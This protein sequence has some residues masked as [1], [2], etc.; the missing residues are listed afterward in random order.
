MKKVGKI[1]LWIVLSLV[2]VVLLLLAINAFDEDLSPEATALV[3]EP[4]TPVPPNENAY[5]TVFGFQAPPGQDAHARGIEIV[6]E[7]EKI[8]KADPFVDPVRS[9]DEMLG[10]DRLQFKGDEK[11]LCSRSPDSSRCITYYMGNTGDVDRLLADN[12]LLLERYFKLTSYPHYRETLPVV[13][14][15]PLPHLSFVRMA[16]QLMLAKTAL[17][18]K[19]G[20]VAAALSQLQRDAVFNRRMAEEGSTLISKL[21][22]LSLLSSDARALSEIIAANKLSA[23]DIAR[24]NAIL[25]PLSAAERNFNKAFRNEAAVMRNA[26]S[27]G[28]KEGKFFTIYGASSRWDRVKWQLVRPFYKPNATINVLSKNYAHIVE[29]DALSAKDLAERTGSGKEAEFIRA[30][31]AL[32]WDMV[33]N[34]VGKF[35][36]A[37][38]IPDFTGYLVRGHK[39][40]GL[41]RLVS[42]QLLLKEN[43]IQDARLEQ[44]IK[45]SGPRYA[46]PYTGGVMRWDEKKRTLYFES[47]DT[48]YTL[49]E[50]IEVAL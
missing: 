43:R 32:R 22:A 16:H 44:F 20:K 17:L 41:M 30:A 13:V 29:L 19:E 31:Q 23:V 18:V 21:I 26:V 3:L 2:F 28:I 1:L 24:A 14:A 10:K 37:I 8:L 47:I 9:L 33:Y 35:I 27:D 11:K 45:E 39:A 7:Y 36:V 48:S 34:P 38:A 42:L 6:G 5:F 12:K 25:K 15:S 4:G 40:D 49:K 50:R 46:D